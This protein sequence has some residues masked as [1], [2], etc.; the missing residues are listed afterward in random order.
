MKTAGKW[1]LG[2]SLIAVGAVLLLCES[3]WHPRFVDATARKPSG[4]AGRFMY[5]DPKEHYKSFQYTLEKLNLT[6]DDFFLD[7]GCG[8]GS[9]LDRAL[10]I[11]HR[12]AG[13]D[14]S[15]DMVALTK[16]KNAQAI[17]EGWLDVREGSAEA[18][19]WDDNTFDVVVSTNAFFFIQN[20]QQFLREAYRVLRSPEPAEGKPGGRFLVI[21]TA[22][23]K[24]IGVFFAPWRSSMSLYSNAEM[25]A[26]L[27]EAGFTAVEA[28]SPDGFI[29]FGQI[30]YGVKS[31]N[32]VL[33]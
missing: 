10:Q 16:E 26:M 20:P 18:L 21:T 5:K 31:F 7:V 8:G 30:G 24:L 1:I 6:A 25:S 28:S 33:T 17:A 27:H 12:A 19:P 11:V 29:Q 9:L 15:P 3:K 23:T 32:T 2:G 22:K 14:H 4:Q 13:L